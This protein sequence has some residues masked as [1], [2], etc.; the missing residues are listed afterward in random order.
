M[1]VLDCPTPTTWIDVV[2]TG[3]VLLFFLVIILAGLFLVWKIG[4]EG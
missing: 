3:E 2:N 4:T 1:L